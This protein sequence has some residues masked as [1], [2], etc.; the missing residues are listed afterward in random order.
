MVRSM[1]CPEMCPGQICIYQGGDFSILARSVYKAFEIWGFTDGHN[2]GFVSWM[3]ENCGSI[4]KSQSLWRVWSAAKSPTNTVKGESLY[5]FQK[6][7]G[8]F[9]VNC[10]MFVFLGLSGHKAL[11][12]HLKWVSPVTQFGKCIPSDFQT[13]HLARIGQLKGPLLWSQVR[14]TPPHTHTHC[15]HTEPACTPLCLLSFFCISFNLMCE[16]K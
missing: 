15:S 5:Q 6:R 13:R 14:R 10:K 2:V 12:L 1:L 7:F 16:C 8:L 3:S 4:Y 11:F 9:R